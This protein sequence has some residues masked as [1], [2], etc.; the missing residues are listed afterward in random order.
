MVLA[1]K[2]LFVAGPPDVVDEEEVFGKPFDDRMIAKAAQQVAALAGDK[3]A[4]LHAISAEDGRKLNELQLDGCPVFDGLA[5]AEG[6]L[7]ISMMV[8]T[9]VCFE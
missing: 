8:G 3:G 4:L 1:D 5:V 9:V 6:K 2:T 7:F